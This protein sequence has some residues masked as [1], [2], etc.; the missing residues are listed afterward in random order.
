MPV[1]VDLRTGLMFA[2]LNLRMEHRGNNMAADVRIL[3]LAEQLVG[4]GNEVVHRSSV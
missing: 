3:K 1:L 2:V 4:F